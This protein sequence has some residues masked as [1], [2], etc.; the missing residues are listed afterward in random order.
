[1][2]L[3]ALRTLTRFINRND[4]LATVITIPCR[5]AVSPPKLAADTP[6]TDVVGPVEICLIHSCRKELD[7][8]ILNAFYCRLDHLVHLNEPLLLDHRLNRCVA[9]VM[10]TNVVGMWNDL[11]KK[12]FLLKIFNQ[13]LTTLITVHSDILSGFLV[14]GR[15]IVDDNDLL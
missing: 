2:I 15:I 4:H 9:S 13:C 7:L 5:D 14:H 6:V 11:H 8:T 10:H 12:S 1:M 3:A